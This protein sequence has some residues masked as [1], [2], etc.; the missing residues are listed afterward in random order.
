M[1]FDSSDFQRYVNNF[2][3]MA[4]QFDAWMNTFLL[5]QGMRF[6]ASVKPRTPVDTGD[7]RNHWKLDGITKQGENLKVWFVNP[8][9]YATFVEYG[10]AKPYK[11]GATEGSGDWVNGYFMMTVA[12]DEVDRNIPQRFDV[13]F[14]AF[15]AKLGVL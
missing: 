3:N 5:N 7:L 2:T 6:L 12:L 15:L 4:S 1:G 9:V 13:E 14:T 10:H 8:M 11:S